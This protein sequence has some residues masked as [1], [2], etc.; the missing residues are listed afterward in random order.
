MA[1][2]PHAK[3]EGLATRLVAAL[4]DRAR[5]M[6]VELR[7]RNGSTEG[8]NDDLNHV[9]IVHV[10]CVPAFCDRV[11]NGRLPVAEEN[12]MAAHVAAR[13]AAHVGEVGVMEIAATREV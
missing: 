7:E 4:K 6:E 1:V 5:E 11:R 3:R 12:C 13:L 2:H 8:S 10:V 9:A